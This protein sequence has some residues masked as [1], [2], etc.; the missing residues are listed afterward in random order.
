MIY[1]SL[2]WE[3]FKTGLFSVGGGLATLPFL[4]K[5]A[6][7][8]G[9]FTAQQVADMLAVSEST[10]GPLGI[11]MSTY[12]GYTTAGIAGSLCAT[13]GLVAP[14]IIVIVIIAAILK[15]FRDNKYVLGAFYGIRPA[16]TALIAAAGLSVAAAALLNTETYTASGRLADLFDWKCIALAAVI[17]V[18]SNLKKLKKLH[19]A[20]FI[21]VSAVV[22]ALFKFAGA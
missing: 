5:M 20:I 13:L 18:L 3:F 22:G 15:H 11:N 7:A 8:T 21:L 14:S 12:A 6:D 10:P 1:L 16:S 2:F 17:A 19:P 4:Y 9:W